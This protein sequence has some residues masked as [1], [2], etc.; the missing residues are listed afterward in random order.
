MCVGEGRNDFPYHQV[1]MNCKRKKKKKPS[2][3]RLTLVSCFVRE[4]GPEGAELIYNLLDVWRRPFLPACHGSV[5]P[6][7]A[8]TT[9]TTS[10]HLNLSPPASHTC[11][12]HCE[13]YVYQ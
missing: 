1:S 3:L 8:V 9:I 7:T 12:V 4:S 10:C 5:F 13:H 11:I 6:R 2:H